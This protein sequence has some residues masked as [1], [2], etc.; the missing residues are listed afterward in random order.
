MRLVLQP[1]YRCILI[2]LYKKKTVSFNCWI[3]INKFIPRALSTDLLT[4]AAIGFYI[5]FLLPL[6]IKEKEITKIDVTSSTPS[7]LLHPFFLKINQFG[8]NKTIYNCYKLFTMSLNTC[9]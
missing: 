7:Y 8:L 2:N 3:K 9:N 4:L 6:F 5:L 1:N